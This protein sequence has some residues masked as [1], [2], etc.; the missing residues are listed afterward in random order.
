MS[1][2]EVE[3]CKQIRAWFRLIEG[4]CRLFFLPSKLPPLN[5]VSGTLNNDSDHEPIQGTWFLQTRTVLGLPESRR[6]RPDAGPKSMHIIIH[7][8]KSN[9][10]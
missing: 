3:A 6:E 10:T 5:V 7:R 2:G 4:F 8:R 1:F 9:C